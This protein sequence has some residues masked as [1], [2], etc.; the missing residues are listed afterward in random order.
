MANLVAQHQDLNLLRLAP[1]EAKDQPLH[2]AA[3]REVD[4]RPHQRDLQNIRAEREPA[5]LSIR[6]DARHPQLLATVRG[7]DHESF[8]RRAGRFCLDE[9]SEFFESR[10]LDPRASGVRIPISNDAFGI[11][12][13]STKSLP[14]RIDRR[15]RT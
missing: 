6:E 7:H 14:W 8:A 15:A 10:G 1:S 3:E 9:D 4:E 2:H 11:D 13:L 12:A 5:T